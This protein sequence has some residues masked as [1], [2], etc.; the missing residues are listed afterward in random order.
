MQEK[1]TD[2]AVVSDRMVDMPDDT[3]PALPVCA[4]S[5]RMHTYAL[6]EPLELFSTPGLMQSGRKAK[7]DIRKRHTYLM[8]DVFGD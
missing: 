5:D 1:I 8:K 6:I 7:Q 4:P 3:T 2:R